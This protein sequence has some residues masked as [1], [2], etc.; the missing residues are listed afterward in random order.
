M[1]ISDRIAVMGV[2]NVTPDS[3]YDGGEHNEVEDAV[4]RAE[5]MVE[6]GADIID[7]GGES[8]RPGADSVPAEKERERVVPVIRELDLDVPISVDTRK[9]EVAEAALDAGAEIVN[10]VTGLE[11]ERM[12]K[13][14]ADRGCDAVIMDSVN[15]PV[16]KG[17]EHPYDDVVG[18]VKAR[19]EKKVER[20]RKAGVGDGQ[21]IIDPGFGFGK[22]YDGDREILRNIE[23]FTHLDYPVLLGCSRKS[24][25]G[26]EFGLEKD[27]RLEVSVAANVLAAYKGADIVRVHDV[28]ETVRAVKVAELMQ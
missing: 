11:D 24:F 20:A 3:F 6:K 28:R 5:E 4:Q 23:A 2:L 17:A 12:R 22:G 1:E 7:I 21:I 10:D 13:L 27:E 15:I 8:T 19:L 18:D 14:V 9:P 16:E 25:F 26:H